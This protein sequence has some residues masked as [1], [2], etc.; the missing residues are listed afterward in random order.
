MAD[1]IL[2]SSLTVNKG[3][4]FQRTLNQQQIGISIA[5]PAAGRVAQIVSHTAAVAL[6]VAGLAALGI[7]WLENT[8]AYNSVQIGVK[9]AST[10]YPLLQVNAGEAFAVRYFGTAVPY[11]LAAAPNPLPP[12]WATATV[13]AVATLLK[14]PADSSVW[15]C[16]VANTSRSS[17]TMSDDR[18][19]HPTWW[20][21]I[22][23]A[24]V[25]LQAPVFDQ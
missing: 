14:D 20:T 8:D 4:Y 13:Y 17:G 9:P 15:L 23:T 5:S 10:F 1:I 25:I 11:L 22:P 3:I 12:A 21:S 6:D 24:D 18:T 2:S 7:G 16:A 19:A